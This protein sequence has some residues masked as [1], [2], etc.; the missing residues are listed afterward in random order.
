M[1]KLLFA[2]V[3]CLFLVGCQTKKDSKPT[4]NLPPSV[5]SDGR[6]VQQ[7]N[8]SKP[9]F[10]IRAF[11]AEEAKRLTNDKTAIRKTVSVNGKSETKIIDTP[12]F[13]S[14]F[15]AFANSDINRPAWGDKYLI[16][17]IPH[18]NH[19]SIQEYW[20]KDNNL[21]TRSIVINRMYGLAQFTIKIHNADK[22]LVNASESFLSYDINI[23]YSVKNIQKLLGSTDSVKIE[24][25]FIRQ[26]KS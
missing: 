10:D 25:E 18:S 21:K 26:Q 17:E 15:Q 19:G 20:A 4:E 9:Y 22:S 13:E 5:L 8:K 2:S 7:V 12:D 16:K 23:G 24:V 6:Q 3:I 1:Y 14:E 11:F